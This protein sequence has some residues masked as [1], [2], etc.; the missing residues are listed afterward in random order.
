[1]ETLDL[2]QK[3]PKHHHSCLFTELQDDYVHDNDYGDGGDDGD[4]DAIGDDYG[5]DDDDC[6]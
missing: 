6:E 3:L 5:D 4:N 1:M 2:R